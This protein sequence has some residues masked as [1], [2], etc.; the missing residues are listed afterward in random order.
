VDGA[1]KYWDFGIDEAALIDIP[2][3][4]DEILITR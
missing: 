3:M 2:A 4:I 1:V